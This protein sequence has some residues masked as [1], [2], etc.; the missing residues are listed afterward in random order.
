MA[1]GAVRRP[2]GITI[3]ALLALVLALAHVVVVLQYLGIIDT[4]TEFVGGDWVGSIV[5]VVNTLL[6]FWV[7]YG[8][9]KLNSGVWIFVNL[10]AVFGLVAGFMAWISGSS[11]LT[12]LPA[13]VISLPILFY[14]N[15][16]P[17]RAAFRV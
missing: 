6:A 9:W 2:V 3:L 13:L 4:D 10:L 16:K 1:A 11:I 8:L 7:A 15:T 17:V 12:M 14:C 5:F